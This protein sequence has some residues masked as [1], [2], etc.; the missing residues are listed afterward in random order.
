M[1]SLDGKLNQILDDRKDHGKRE[2]VAVSKIDSKRPPEHSLE[3]A[4]WAEQAVI[5]FLNYRLKGKMRVRPATSFEDAGVIKPGQNV[6]DEM[7]YQVDAVVE[8]E[9]GPVMA[10]QVTTASNPYI[11]KEKMLRISDEPTTRLETMRSADTPIP[12][13]LI[14]LDPR[15]VESFLKDYKFEKHQDLGDKIMND[16]V[17]GLNFVMIRVKTDKEKAKIQKLLEF[18]QHRPETSH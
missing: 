2:R 6:I 1:R 4:N 9:W 12:K 8:D 5:D 16:I 11:Q 3:T 13:I 15:A 14:G 18:F 17:A 10:I 7:G